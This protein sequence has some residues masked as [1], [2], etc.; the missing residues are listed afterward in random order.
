MQWNKIAKLPG[1]VG[2]CASEDMIGVWK[3]MEPGM[4]E[5]TVTFIW[6]LQEHKAFHEETKS[7]RKVVK[8]KPM[9]MLALP[10]SLITETKLGNRQH[11]SFT[12]QQGQTRFY[13]RFF[14]WCRQQIRFLGMMPNA[15]GMTMK[16]HWKNQ[17]RSSHGYCMQV[18]QQDREAAPSNPHTH[19]NHR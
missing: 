4:V 10:E 7:L 17:Q 18:W 8:W 3:S 6:V 1:K 9:L 14:S 16:A 5:I 13:K 2:S 15:R 12:Q 11:Q 19:T